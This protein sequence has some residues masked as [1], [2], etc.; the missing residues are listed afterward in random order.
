MLH[1]SEPASSLWTAQHIRWI[2]HCFFLCKS[3]RKTEKSFWLETYCRVF[4][5]IKQSK[6]SASGFCNTGP[7]VGLQSD[8]ATV[9]CYWTTCHGAA[10]A[11]RRWPWLKDTQ[12]LC[13]WD[14]LWAEAPLSTS[15]ST[16]ELWLMPELSTGPLGMSLNSLQQGNDCIN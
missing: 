11:Q 9:C 8:H 4:G 10:S 15:L 5:T 13:S 14:W 7:F 1:Q 3:G 2:L 16:M 12:H 6:Q